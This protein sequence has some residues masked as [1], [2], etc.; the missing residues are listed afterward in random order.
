MSK[1]LI[2]VK[3]IAIQP[4]HC[5][6]GLIW[7]VTEVNEYNAKPGHSAKLIGVIRNGRQIVQ[8]IAFQNS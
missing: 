8:M 4:G 5:R 1:Q 2:D 7:L 6:G 3:E